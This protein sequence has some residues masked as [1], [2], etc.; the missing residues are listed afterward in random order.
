MSNV[1][2]SIEITD[3]K[4]QFVSLVDKAANKKKFLIAKQED[5]AAQ[6]QTFGKIIKADSEKHHV[7]GIVYEPMVADAHDNFM[8]EAEIEKAAHWFLKNG[9]KIDIQHSFEEAKGVSVVE[10]SVTKADCTIEGEEIR[11]GTWIMTV[12]ITDEDIW[13]SVENGDITGLSMGGVGKYAAEETELEKGAQKPQETHTAESA[14]EK[15]GL[16]KRLAKM[17]G[18]EMIEKGEV[19]DL[20]NKRN[21]NERFW[22]AIY[23]LRDVLFEW[24]YYSCTEKWESDE[25]K[26][27]EALEDFSTIISELLKSGESITKTLSEGAKNG[28]D[29]FSKP[30]SAESGIEKAGKK[31]SAANKAR[32]TEISQSLS[33]FIKDFDDPEPEDNPDNDNNDE[34]DDD[35]NKEDIQKM[36]DESIEKA[37]KPV[38][39]A[40]NPQTPPAAEAKPELTA[41]SV[42]KM[43]EEAVAKALQPAEPV[44]EIEKTEEGPLDEER[45]SKMIETA[46]SEVLKA[47]GVPSQ[48]NTEKPV[49]KQEQHYLHGIL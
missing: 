16:M 2:K 20:Y 29:V 19:M 31:M 21:I 35:M 5:G 17:L 14:G 13:K 46:I 42:Q 38:E 23:A 3:A 33:D 27:R 1:A 41:E 12:E 37:L 22:T 48:I 6:F 32:L 28:M 18:I 45:V 9:D 39:K 4:I 26:V 7:T 25:E 36:I 34:E 11:K 10:S 43:I 30:D 24:D 40:E 15:T 47:R 44:Q 8:T 49:E